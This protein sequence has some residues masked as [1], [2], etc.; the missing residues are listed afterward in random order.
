MS[1]IVEIKIYEVEHP[2]DP[3]TVFSLT[4]NTA[5]QYQWHASA[6]QEIQDHG[7]KLKAFSL[8]YEP[9]W[10]SDSDENVMHGYHSMLEH[11]EETVTLAGPKTLADWLATAPDAKI[12]VNSE[13]QVA[14]T[15]LAH[16]E[17]ECVSYGCWCHDSPWYRSKSKGDVLTLE[18]LDKAIEDVKKNNLPIPNPDLNSDEPENPVEGST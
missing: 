1:L 7:D 10:E 5:S 6:G 3:L 18:M 13:E 17:H 2:D 15:M 9:L 8:Y 16:P 4:G 11:D 14:T 12:E